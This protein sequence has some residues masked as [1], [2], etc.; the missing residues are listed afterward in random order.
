MGAL[1]SSQKK[2]LTWYSDSTRWEHYTPRDDDIVIGTAWKCGTT[3]MQ[4]IVSS[5]VFLSPEPRPIWE[6][7]P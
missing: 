6:I 4:Q 3:W 1:N 5:L 7:S 2:Y